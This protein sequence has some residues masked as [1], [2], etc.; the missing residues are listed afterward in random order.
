MWKKKILWTKSTLIFSTL[1]FSL[2][3]ILATWVHVGVPQKI[4]RK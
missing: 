3:A 4:L 2:R 1:L